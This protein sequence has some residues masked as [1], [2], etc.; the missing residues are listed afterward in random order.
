[1]DKNTAYLLHCKLTMV[2][3]AVC[4]KGFTYTDE[5]MSRDSLLEF[6]L[7]GIVNRAQAL[8]NQVATASFGEAGYTLEEVH[9]PPASPY[10]EEVGSDEPIW[11][12][13]QAQQDRADEDAELHGILDEELHTD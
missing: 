9:M 1:M 3:D 7:K 4:P 10:V 11:D 6:H 13:A 12:K 5:G 2:L 8:N